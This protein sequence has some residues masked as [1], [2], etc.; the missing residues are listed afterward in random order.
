MTTALIPLDRIKSNPWQTRQGDPDPEY[1]KALAMDIAANS[2]LQY[3]V[4]RLINGDGG[5][6]GKIGYTDP[7]A[8]LAAG[9]AVNIQL[10]F[11]HNRLAAYRWL[12]DLRD[13]SNIPGDYS[14]MPVDLRLLTDEQMAIMAWSENEKRRD[15]TPLERA[16]AI[17][18]RMADFGW[19][20]AQVAEQL[21]ISRP[22]V[23]NTLR[24]LK[25]PEE[26]LQVMAAG[27]I[28]ERVAMA[29]SSL[30]DLPESL[31]ETAERSWNTQPSRIIEQALMG[32]MTSNEIREA[33][34]SISNSYGKKLKAADFSIDEVFFIENIHSQACRDCELRFKERNLCLATDCFARKTKAIRAAYLEKASQACGIP[35]MESQDANLYDVTTFSKWRHGD[36]LPAILAAKC[37][38]LRLIYSRRDK[39]MVNGDYSRVEGFEE[40]MVVC[41]K[42][43]QFCSCLKGLQALEEQRKTVAGKNG[44]KP[45]EISVEEIA[46]EPPGDELHAEKQAEEA[47]APDA[48]ALKELARGARKEKREAQKQAHYVMEEAAQR[49]AMGLTQRNSNTWIALM[50]SDYQH[51]DWKSHD[52]WE[53]FLALATDLSN[54]RMPYEVKSLRQVTEQMN[55][56]L[57]ACGLDPIELAVMAE[58]EVVIPQGK[59]LVELWA[60]EAEHEQE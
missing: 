56:L 24:L 47:I 7:V 23:S 31:R 2:L 3:P 40:A 28:T 18:K 49:I 13:H 20:Q 34:E 52:M 57:K 10:A 32:E 58:V 42:K 29:L 26:V 35:P 14:S 6:V 44:G 1:I 4:G 51:A 45:A 59:P 25:L 55:E 39:Q 53:I 46:S 19:S 21:G 38:N 33:V 36:Q 17:E 22:V 30:F 37:P 60:G 5:L 27:D 9:P 16:R 48:E 43:E 11:G 8:I 12:Y 41:G 54:K 50:R 15:H